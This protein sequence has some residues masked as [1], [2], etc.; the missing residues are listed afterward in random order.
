MKRTAIKRR[1]AAHGFWP[2]GWAFNNGWGPLSRGQVKK[3]QK[4]HGLHADGI[5]GPITTRALNA[6][7]V[8]ASKGERARAVKWALSRVGIVEH[9]AGSNQGPYIT[10]WQELSGY[11]GGGVAWCQCFV[12]ASAYVGTRKRLNP[13]SLGGYTVSVVSMA[14]RGEHGLKRVS[15]E[16]AR[17]GDWVY[18]N[19]PGGDSVDH[20][21]LF[22]SR[23]GSTVHTLE[24]NTSAEGSLGSQSNGGGVFKRTRDRSLIAAV[25][26][27]PFKS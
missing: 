23:N 6:P 1:L 10:S 18:F 20:V 8:Q 3:F 9:P 14:G 17:P 25:V 5:V 22:L 7:G 4:A 2:K 26:R 16:A 21:G 12:N 27:P 19:W 24:G 11:P 15:L 13:A